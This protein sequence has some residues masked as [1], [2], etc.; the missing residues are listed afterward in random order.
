MTN[1]PASYLA[2]LTQPLHFTPSCTCHPEDRKQYGI[3]RCKHK[4]AFHECLAAELAQSQ[5]VPGFEY[6]TELQEVSTDW[7]DNAGG[8]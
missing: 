5:T 8:S 7:P 4:N 2:T 6:Y 1:T 3:A